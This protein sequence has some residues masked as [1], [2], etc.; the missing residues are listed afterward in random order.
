MR[1]NLLFFAQHLWVRAA[2]SVVAW[3]QGV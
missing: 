2:R 3:R 1:N